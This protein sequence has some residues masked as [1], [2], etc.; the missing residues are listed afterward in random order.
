MTNLQDYFPLGYH[1]PID[2]K[3]KWQISESGDYLE[4]LA[5]PKRETIGDMRV[6][7]EAL[8]DD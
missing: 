8:M 7:F 3:G 5:H 2:Y 1:P 4:R 6:Y